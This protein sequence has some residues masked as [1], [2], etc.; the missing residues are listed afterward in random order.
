MQ[1]VNQLRRAK[2]V[3]KKVNLIVLSI[4]CGCFKHFFLL[5]GQIRP[6]SL[7]SLVSKVFI[8]VPIY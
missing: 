8:K 3:M 2:E 6:E 1:T 4:H 5:K 7:Q